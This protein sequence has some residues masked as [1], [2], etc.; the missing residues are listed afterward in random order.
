MLSNGE[1]L[2]KITCE[3]REIERITIKRATHQEKAT[4]L[5]GTT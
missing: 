2:Y 3:I 5:I 1:N 4:F